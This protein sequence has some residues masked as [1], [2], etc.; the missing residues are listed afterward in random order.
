[1]YV[2]ASIDAASLAILLWS[3]A[4]ER[5]RF[6]PFWEFIFTAFGAKSLSKSGP[7]SNEFESVSTHSYW[8]L[9]GFQLV[10]I[11]AWLKMIYTHISSRISPSDAT[12]PPIL[13]I[14]MR[15][16]R[17]LTFCGSGV[18]E[19]NILR[20]AALEP[21][22]D[23]TVASTSWAESLLVRHQWTTLWIDIFAPELSCVYASLSTASVSGSGSDRAFAVRWNTAAVPQVAALPSRMQKVF[24]R[25]AFLRGKL[26]PYVISR[27]TTDM[28]CTRCEIF[29]RRDGDLAISHT[30]QPTMGGIFV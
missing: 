1:M 9:V 7:L 20:S 30:P 13:C 12:L 21:A 14:T 4:C 26:T 17:G 28:I 8:S 5:A 19:A 29:S 27:P 18:A 16:Y 3:V 2:V 10:E 6:R 15:P 11:G 24:D 25:S 22:K 23:S